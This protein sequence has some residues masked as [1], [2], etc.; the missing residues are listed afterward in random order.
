MAL[1]K[2]TAKTVKKKP[3]KRK[4]PV[5]KKVARESTRPVGAPPTQ[6]RVEASKYYAGPV[7][8][9]FVEERPFEFPAGY[10]DNRAV[11]MVRDPHWI[12]AYWEVN[13]NCCREIRQEIGDEAYSRARLFL[14]VYDTH[15]GKH[16]DIEVGGAR[17]WYIRVPA[18][19]RTYFVEI[20]FLTADGRFLAAARSN[21][22]TTP[23]DTM[24]DVIDEQWMI[25]DWD[26]LYALSGGIGFGLAF[27]TLIAGQ[28]NGP[29]ALL[30]GRQLRTD[31]LRRDRAIG[32]RHRPGEE[33]R[34]A[35]GWD[36]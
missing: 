6:E 5:K 19:N 35:R 15:S 21:A 33:D 29:A 24:S 20:G 30:A 23:L 28:E 22:V 26:K 16:H 18:P 25:P 27:F 17:N 1:K 11:L 7:M 8:Q 4:T 2:K 14:R 10:G 13:E 31:R 32:H 12:H 9:K 36:F 34:P 3:A